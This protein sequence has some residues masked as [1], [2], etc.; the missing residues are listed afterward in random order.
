MNNNVIVNINELNSSLNR[1]YENM[2]EALTKSEIQYLE[3]SLDFEKLNDK[4]FMIQALKSGSLKKLFDSKYKM[5]TGIIVSQT[6]EIN[7][8]YTKINDL[9]QNDRDARRRHARDLIEF[10]NH[11]VL[12]KKKNLDDGK[13]YR[14][15]VSSLGY[16]TDF[17]IEG[18][19]DILNR[20]GVDKQDGLNRLDQYKA[21][22]ND[23]FE[24]NFGYTKYYT[25]I[26]VGFLVRNTY[27]EKAIVNIK[28]NAEIHY[29]NIYIL[30]KMAANTTIG[31]QDMELAYKQVTQRY[32]SLGK[33]AKNLIDELFNIPLQQFRIVIDYINAVADASI[34]CF[35]KEY[36]ELKKIYDILKS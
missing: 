22:V 20:Y 5:K 4:K 21:A 31:L 2:G 18:I 12:L 25:P 35:S 24:D 34:K 11:S 19:S 15:I 17:F 14:L 8:I 30:N 32:A 36:E 3:E 33:D 7:D 6:K 1:V 23:F 26:D 16:N 10:Y 28:T 29:K 27:L 13:M 9:L